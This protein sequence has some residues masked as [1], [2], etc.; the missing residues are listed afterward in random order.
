[1]CINIP[2]ISKNF[3]IVKNPHVCTETGGNRSKHVRVSE[4]LFSDMEGPP[5]QVKC[6]QKLQSSYF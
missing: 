5:W 2:L 3:S 6:K 4:R 1:M